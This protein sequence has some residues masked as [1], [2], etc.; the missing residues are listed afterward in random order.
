[1]A[2]HFFQS[3]LQNGNIYGQL[4]A[5]LTPQPERAAIFKTLLELNQA[6]YKPMKE[7]DQD[8]LALRTQALDDYLALP[9]VMHAFDQPMILGGVPPKP[10]SFGESLS[11]MLFGKP[12]PKTV[13]PP[14]SDGSSSSR[15]LGRDH[16]PVEDEA[17]LTGKQKKQ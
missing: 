3:S 9:E 5:G 14:R 12:K 7:N 6:R 1:M 10:V 15:Y 4:V 17:L 11:L 8:A 13:S 2:Y 16:E